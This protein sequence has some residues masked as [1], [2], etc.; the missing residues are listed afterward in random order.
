[1]AQAEVLATGLPHS[2][3]VIFEHSGHL[4]FVEEPERFLAV[5]GEWLDEQGATAKC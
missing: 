2:R 3:L 5:A 4:P 1:V